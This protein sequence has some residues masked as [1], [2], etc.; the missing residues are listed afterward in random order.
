MISRR[1]FLRRASASM[2]GVPFLRLNDALALQPLVD[3]YG[4]AFKRAPVLSDPDLESAVVDHLLPE[5]L[6]TILEADAQWYRVNGGYVPR[7]VLQPVA[8]YERPEI[9]AQAGFPATVIT[10]TTLIREYCSVLAPILDRVGWGAVLHVV[11]RLRDDYG[12]WWYGVST[13]ADGSLIGWTP[14]LHWAK[15]MLETPL[16][17]DLLRIDL[18]AQMIEAY[19]VGNSIARLPIRVLGKVSAGDTVV[20]TMAISSAAPK[21]GSPYHL[22]LKNG[23]TIYGVWWH[24]DFA[25]SS[26]QE[27]NQSNSGSI[28]LPAYAAQALYKL[29]TPNI[30][31]SIS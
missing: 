2:V 27:F 23:L 6:I 19:H 13:A 31:V 24:N 17:A 9:A 5:K 15:L 11:D 4:R 21:L 22:T 1:K 3:Q 26:A 18:A 10:P 20:E 28:E 30:A 8:P 16:F 12:E 14:A 25:N 29:I 7:A